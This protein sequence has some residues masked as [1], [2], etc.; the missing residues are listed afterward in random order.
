[1]RLW[2]ERIPS[3]LRKWR[4]IQSLVEEGIVEAELEEEH[5]VS[6][7]VTEDEEEDTVSDTISEEEEEASE[8]ESET[9]TASDTESE[10]DPESWN[11]TVSWPATEDELD[12]EGH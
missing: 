8:R 11:D 6:D 7:T 2:S 4:L 1:M 12:W 10:E 9:D 3:I 5:T